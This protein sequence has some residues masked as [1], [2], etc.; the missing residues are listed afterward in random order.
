M[1]AEFPLPSV[2]AAYADPLITYKLQD[3]FQVDYTEYDD[4]GRDFAL[5]SGGAG[6][7]RWYLF[8]DGMT[9]AEAAVL[10]AW[11]ET[12]KLGP[13]GLS[14][15]AA[16][17]RDPDTTLLYSGVRVESYERPVHKLKAVQQ[18]IITLV[19]FP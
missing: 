7:Q 4:G 2:N 8:F 15:Y 16:N 19:K 13:D 14:A 5:G 12:M 3:E 10:D 6:T 9:A 17:F 11:V 1:P 18:R